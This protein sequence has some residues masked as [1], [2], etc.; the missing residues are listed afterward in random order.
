LWK[1]QFPLISTS[2]VVS[3]SCIQNACI[4]T[5]VSDISFLNIKNLRFYFGLVKMDIKRLY[6]TLYIVQENFEDV[7]NAVCYLLLRQ[8]FVKLYFL[9]S[10]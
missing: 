10:N 6:S 4:F 5:E 2:S 8:Q 1:T 7:T 9:L 3:F